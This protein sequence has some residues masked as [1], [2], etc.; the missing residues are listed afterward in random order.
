MIKKE[1]LHVSLYYQ[2]DALTPPPLPH[3]TSPHINGEFMH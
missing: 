1:I 3:T 2:L